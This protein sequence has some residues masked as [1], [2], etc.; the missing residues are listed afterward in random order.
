MIFART[1]CIGISAALSLLTTTAMAA[2]PESCRNVRIGDGGWTDNVAQNA[3][4]KILL[5]PLGYQ[6]SMPLL[7]APIIFSSI[8][9]KDIDIFLNAWSPAVDSMVKPYLQEGTIVRLADT[10]TGAKWTLAV[11]R[12]AYD[13]GLKNFADIG[14]F[15]DKLDNR[16]YGIESGSDGNQAILNMLDA[17][18][19]GLK[20]FEL[21]ESSEQAMLSEVQRKIASKDWIVFMGWAPH[22]MNMKFDMAYLDGGDAYFGP[23]QGEATV[24]KAAR[25]GYA[26]ECPNLGTFFKELQFTVE[27]ESEIMAFILDE[28]LDPPAAAAK[29]LHTHPETLDQWLKGVVSMDGKDAIPLVVGAVLN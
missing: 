15:K 7:G 26:E 10:M 16:I 13:A 28:G 6:V 27:M 11:P 9:N 22:P 2:D 12:Y 3:V 18:S 14:K 1:S 4:A 5:E 17:N 21:V 8:K 23:N 29:F 25:V 19:F 24:W 20:G